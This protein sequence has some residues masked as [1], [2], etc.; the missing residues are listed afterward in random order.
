MIRRPPRSTLFPYTTLFR[1]LVPHLRQDAR[2]V[3]HPL[4]LL[5]HAG[6]R[7]GVL[8][9]A[10]QLLGERGQ[11]EDRLDHVGKRG[12]GLARRRQARRGHEERRPPPT[13]Q[14]EQPAEWSKYGHRQTVTPKDVTVW[15]VTVCCVILA[16]M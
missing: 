9:H 7:V 2:V 16:A 14:A 11:D 12:H 1:S 10:V 13:G 4:Q 15:N 5:D 6:K 8:T 3:P